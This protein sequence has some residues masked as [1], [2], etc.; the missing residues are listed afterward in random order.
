MPVVGDQPVADPHEPSH[1]GQPEEASQAPTAGQVLE[2]PRYGVP[3]RPRGPVLGHED[4]GVL[5]LA[6]GHTRGPQDVFVL[7]RHAA[8]PPGAI[9]F[10]D[11]A[12][13]V[14]AEAAVA[15]VYDGVQS[16]LSLMRSIC[17][18]CTRS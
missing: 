14:P 6:G 17:R 5:S 10:P 16:R 13:H 7:V 3:A 4:H 11:P 8:E 12:D 9:P 18:R 1:A 15:V 2:D